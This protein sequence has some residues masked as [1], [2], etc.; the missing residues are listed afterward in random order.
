MTQATSLKVHMKW[1]FGNY[2]HVWGI[3]PTWLAS[4]PEQYNM[5]RE[6]SRV[7]IITLMLPTLLLVQDNDVCCLYK[8]RHIQ[9][10]RFMSVIVQS[11]LNTWQLCFLG[12]LN[13]HGRVLPTWLCKFPRTAQHWLEKVLET[14]I[15]TLMLPT[16]AGMSINS[17]LSNACGERQ[18]S[19]IN[20]F[21][22]LACT[23]RLCVSIV[24][25]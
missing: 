23:W 1:I 2:K 3:T 16:L 21:D 15:I 4:G 7:W 10:Y 14:W 18:F 5:A 17:L 12:S 9:L 11:W 8:R 22:Y 25:T 20:L 19:N 24:T 13:M 6:S